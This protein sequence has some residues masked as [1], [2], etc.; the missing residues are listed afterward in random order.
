MHTLRA[1]QSLNQDAEV[2]KVE[3]IESI[4]AY[5]ILRT[6]GLVVNER[7]V[8]YGRVPSVDEIAS[9]LSDALVAS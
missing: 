8:S 2:V 5:G 9:F 1:L 4:M 6:P 7:V 3:D